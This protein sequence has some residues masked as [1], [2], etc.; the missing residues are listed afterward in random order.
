MTLKLTNTLTKEKEEFT[1]IEPNTVRMYTCG[2][3]VYDYIHIGNLRAFILSDFLRRT[4]EYLGYDVTQVMNITD[5]GHLVGDGDEGDDKMTRALKRHDMDITTANMI[6]VA[7]IYADAFVDDLNDLNILLPHHLPKAS[8]HIAENIDIIS[9]LEA[10]GFVYTTSDGVYFDTSKMPDYGKL[11]NLTSDE[12]HSR[13]NENSEKKNYRDFA[14]WKFDDTNGWESPWGHGFPGWHIE[15]SGMSMKYLGNHF[16]IH[17]GGEDLANTH[18]NNEIAQSECCTGESYVNYWLHNA[19]VNVE[20]GKMAKS[21]GNHLTLR[22]LTEKGYDPLDYRY[23]LLQGH[24]RSPV[25]FSWD[26]LDAAA[27]GLKRARNAVSALKMSEIIDVTDNPHNQKFIAA[28][29]DDINTPQAL[30]ALHEMLKDGNLS[31][32]EKYSLAYSFDRVL[33]LDLDKVEEVEIPADVAKL[34]E[35]RD[36]ARADNNWNESDRLQFFN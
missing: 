20:S 7:G 33:G 27:T 28:L 15:C 24:Y 34:L 4:F 29:E 30:A 35:A 36:T 17:T 21:E 18:H 6:K 13:I 19:F 22:T 8:D 11:G 32:E 3:T 14:L 25:T 12:D 31:D 1:A 5:V 26:A 16:D 23:W 9:K 10:K 2:P